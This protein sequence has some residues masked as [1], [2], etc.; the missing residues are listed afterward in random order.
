MCENNDAGLEVD[1]DATRE[2]SKGDAFDLAINDF[3]FPTDGFK[4][5]CCLLGGGIRTA[6]LPSPAQE[7]I[8]E[9]FADRLAS[10]YI[11]TYNALFER[12][13]RM[14]AYHAHSG[15]R[16]ACSP[17]RGTFS[18]PTYYCFNKDVNHEMKLTYFNSVEDEDN[19]ESKLQKKVR[20]QNNYGFNIMGEVASSPFPKYISHLEQST[21][22]FQKGCHGIVIRLYQFDPLE[23]LPT[24]PNI[25]ELPPDCRKA[26]TCVINWCHESTAFTLSASSESSVRFK[27][28]QISPLSSDEVVLL[29]VSEQSF[30]IDHIFCLNQDSSTS[31]CA[32]SHSWTLQT[33]NSRNSALRK[34][35]GLKVAKKR[36]GTTRE[37]SQETYFQFPYEWNFD[38]Y[39]AKMEGNSSKEYYHLNTF[40]PP[41]NIN[42][43]STLHH[44]AFAHSSGDAFAIYCHVDQNDI[45]SVHAVIWRAD[46]GMPEE[47]QV[48]ENV[49]CVTDSDH[50]TNVIA[51]DL[52]DS[53]QVAALATNSAI[54]LYRY[55]PV[56][57]QWK[58]PLSINE[59]MG[60][61]IHIGL[62]E[63]GHMLGVIIGEEQE[64]RGVIVYEKTPD[65]E[66]YSRFNDLDFSS[67]LHDQ[68]SINVSKSGVISIQLRDSNSE[69]ADETREVRMNLPH[70]SQGLTLKLTLFLFPIGPQ[71]LS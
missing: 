27:V 33:I 43:R 38:N 11:T 68:I 3:E 51:A 47:L 20:K 70:L 13:I 35:V 22:A 17:E 55:N 42:T 25:G 2:C 49:Q 39:R 10:N 50:S 23:P 46:D 31:D 36:L 41:A 53:G 44:V 9:R 14:E 63:F 71:N 69:V 40:E 64:E 16:K 34:R 57:K 54:Y 45:Q 66:N 28:S 5:H 37:E 60:N 8:W 21:I 62:S 30:E 19:Y 65:G 18:L 59:S 29:N 67:I 56:L 15:T 48:T 58:E 26:G 52:S 32:I 61:I 7:Q 6:P 12:F 4:R 24:I 1:S